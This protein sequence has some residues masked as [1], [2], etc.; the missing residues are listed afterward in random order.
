LASLETVA[1]PRRCAFHNDGHY[2]RYRIHALVWRIL[3]RDH[4]CRS[5]SRPLWET[6]FLQMGKNFENFIAIGVDDMFIAVAAWHNT[7]LKFPGK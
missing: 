2:Q 1:G 3:R 7:E 5:I 6:L 4:A